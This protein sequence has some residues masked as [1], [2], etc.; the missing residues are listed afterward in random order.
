MTGHSQTIG[1]YTLEKRLGA[2]GMG[3]VYQA[4]DSRLDR[5]VAIKL[6][7]PEQT[8]SETARERFRREARAAA[9][10]SHPSIVQ[11]HDIVESVESDAI[12]M[13]LVD[14]EPLSQRI[15]RGPLPVGEA[16]RLGREI[17]EGL[18]AAHAK[19]LIHRDLK[20]DNVMITSEGRAKILDFGLAKRLEGEASLTADHRVIGTFRAM[21]PEQAQ[22]LPLDARSDLFSLGLLLYEMLSGR[23]PF[24]GSSTLETLTR[25]CTHRQTP[26]REIGMGVPEGLSALVDQLLEKEPARRPQS[27]REVASALETFGTGAVDVGATW[28]DGGVPRTAS[29]PSMAA[30]TPV[31]E[32]TSQVYPAGKRVLRWGIVVA[33]LVLLAAGLLWRTRRQN[34]G[35][36]REP[37]SPVRVVVRKPELDAGA[38]EAS[39]LLASSLRI[40]VLRALLNFKGISPGEAGDVSG[41]PSQVARALAAQEIIT[42]RLDCVRESCQIALQRV[43]GSDGQTLWSSRSFSIDADRPYLMEEAVQVY[44]ADAYS[45]FQRQAGAARLEVRP[46]DYAQCLR[47]RRTFEAKRAGES[48]SPEALFS[49]LEALRAS[50]PRFLDAYVFEAE[51]RQQRYNTR[52]DPADLDRAA[53]L[54]R[55]AQQIAPTDPRPL[56]GQFGVALLRGQWDRAEEAL[57]GLERLQPGDP[58]LLV[59][60]ARLLE[61]RGESEKALALMRE[62]VSRYPSWRNLFQAAKMES[63]LGHFDAARRDAEQLL[64]N[65]PESYDGLTELAEI[66]LLH[67]DLRRASDLYSRLVERYPRLG[68]ISNLGTTQMYLGSYREAEASFRKALALEPGN[69]FTLLSLADAVT[70][71]GRPEEASPVYRE[72]VRQARLDASDWHVLSVRAQAQAHLKDG[73]GAVE[74][75]QKMLRIGPEGAQV[76]YDTSLIYVLLGQRTVALYNAR[77]ALQQ[78][79]AS[80]LF[81]LPWFDPLRLDPTFAAELRPRPSF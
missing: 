44:L 25:I 66:E 18:A 55:Q 14:G 31:R 22:G 33:L 15:E 57:A 6:I 76:A 47:L 5:R 13:E 42:S 28:V 60:R 67:G 12:V 62:G 46:D 7:R 61:K 30:P 52:Q 10:L 50:S 24:E 35:P 53:E 69:A 17:A 37:D 54:L 78:G 49:K 45:G 68:E 3:E 20:P 38:G 4:Y 65:Y 23:S 26:L 56:T 75:V 81:A 8:E 16:V 39:Q 72:V 2:G 9:G 29:R 21:S 58:G 19:G 74:T 11:I 71:A 41:S 80:R 40:A 64:A 73:P 63:S 77:R 27:A 51:V 79:I 48:L 32:R 34:P 59:R 36:A 43:R 70:L 1:P